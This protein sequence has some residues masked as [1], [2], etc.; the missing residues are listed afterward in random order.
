MWFDPTMLDPWTKAIEPA[1]SEAGYRPDRIDR[2]HHNNKID[3]EIIAMIRKSRF[4]VA[5]LTGNRGG[6]YFEAGFAIGLGT[7]V[8][9]TVRSDHLPHVHFDNRQYNFVLWDL[10]DLP[11]FKTQ[12]K[13][14]IEATIGQGP[15]PTAS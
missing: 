10:A 11:N 3:D 7:P 14:R 5:D 4:V 1:I 9:W 12:L 8:V 2:I 13:N 6:V 15:H